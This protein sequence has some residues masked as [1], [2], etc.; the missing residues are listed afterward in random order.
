MKNI[1]V[2]FI[3]T[4]AL[5][6]SF[7][8]AW[9]IYMAIAMDHATSAA[10]AHLNL[11]GWVTMALFGLYYMV[12]PAAARS[13]LASIHYFVHTVGVLIF[14][15]GIVVAVQSHS[16]GLAATGALIVFASMLIFLYTVVTVSLR[17][18]TEESIP[19]RPAVQ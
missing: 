6:A 9:G 5:F 16:E 12:A 3:A 8:M 15:P 7:G 10:H 18:S 17:V 11:I 4:A 19:A 2:L 1:G 13:R 14:A